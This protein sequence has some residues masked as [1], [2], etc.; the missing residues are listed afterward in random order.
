[1][2]NNQ[3]LALALSVA[4]GAT[5]IS[6]QTPGGKG[7]L[8]G[9]DGPR[10]KDNTVAPVAR[11]IP[12][13]RELHGDRFVDDYFWLRAKAN[14]DVVRH[15]EAENAY[16]SAIMKPLE[17]L[18]DQLYK[19]LLGRIKE[20]DLTVPLKDGAYYYYSR[21][22]QGKQYPIFCRKKGSLDAPEEVTLDVNALAQAEKFM[23]V[24]AYV[25]SDDGHLLAYSTDNTGFRDYRLHVKDLRTG[26]V[27]ESPVEKVL[28]VAWA[29]DNRT[30]F[31][32]I[33]D[34]AKRSVP[35]LSPHDG[36]QR[37][38][39]RVRREGRA[40]QRPGVTLAEQGLPLHGHRQPDRVRSAVRVRRSSRPARGRWWPRAKTTMNTTSSTAATCFYIRSNRD[41]RNFALMTAP[42]ANPGEGGLD[43]HGAASRRC[44]A[45]GRHG[46]QG[47]SGAV[48]A[49]GRPAAA[50]RLDVRIERLADHS[51][52][53]ARLQCLSR[54]QSRVRH[55]GGPL[56]VPVV[57]H[58]ELG[59]RV[60]RG[61]APF[62][63]AQ[64][65]RDPRRLRPDAL[66]LGAD[67]GHG[68]RRHEGARLPRLPEIGDAATG[69]PRSISAP[70]DPTASRTTSA[71]RPTGSVS[72]TA[73]SS[74][75]SRTF[76]AAAISASHGTTPGG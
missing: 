1:M 58:A 6:G 66:R 52:P 41:G 39:A 46:V 54:R 25:V 34:A 60:R 65:D 26:Q 62:D 74:T 47:S 14:P 9:K 8:S 61:G 71:S 67:H 72:S 5:M 21:T 49:R 18:Q 35:A 40:L 44:D 3:T 10:G 15:L 75:P 13:V 69:P 37:R 12:D 17:P 23:Q 53:R 68:Q 30:L 36:R 20:T 27:L 59:V 73:A 51:V 64:G 7:S 2:R 76:A 4:L 48:G 33:P 16:A 56:H 43:A 28:S 32:T 45:P 63:A 70:T 29:A 19:E 50:S 31:Y 57:H 42:V 38:R 24:G 22:E 11:K 55:D